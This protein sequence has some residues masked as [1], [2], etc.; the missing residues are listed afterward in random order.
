M[1]AHCV[2]SPILPSLYLELSALSHGQDMAA[3][4]TLTLTF[5]LSNVVHQSTPRASE[6][7][8]F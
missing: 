3:A 8:W 1:G 5:H 4:E 2:F 7:L 6:L